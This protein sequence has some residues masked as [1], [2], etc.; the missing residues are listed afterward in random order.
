MNLSY[1]EKTFC[2]LFF[3]QMQGEADYDVRSDVWNLKP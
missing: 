1:T 3:G 2:L